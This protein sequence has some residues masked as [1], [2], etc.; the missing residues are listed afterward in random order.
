MAYS[1]AF[2]RRLWVAPQAAGAL[3]TIPNT[4]GTW[5][6]TGAQVIPFMG[7]PSFLPGNPV[8][9][10]PF[11]TGTASTIAGVRGRNSGSP[12]I[13]FP[14]IPSGTPATVPNSDLILKAA[15]GKAAVTG[16]GICTYS[17]ADAIL[18]F[19]A[20][21]YD[22]S[23]GSPTNMYAIGCLPKTLTFSLNGNFLTA[24]ADCG[25]IG[26]ADSNNFAAYAGTPDAAIAGGLTTFPAEPGSPTTAGHT[27][28]GFGGTVSVDGQSLGELRGSCA[29][30]VS[31]GYEYIE[32]A[33]TD[34]YA[35]T[36]INGP[37]RMRL[38]DFSFLNSDS[39]ALINAK[40]KAFNKTPMNVILSVTAGGTGSTVTFNLNNVQ[41]PQGAFVVNGSAVDVKFG[42]AT[43]HASTIGA[44]D[45]GSLV[46]S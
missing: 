31:C 13:D 20:L 17:F 15:F 12:K 8:N 2:R 36:A 35:L 18:P 10:Q 4:S 22:E 25:A 46:I 34:A 16:S 21:L 42:G 30:E 45:D 3:R 44:T 19:L 41:L 7:D 14:F 37:R 40:Q 27:V 26:V 38:S 9:D 5:T 28:T 23:G 6:N 24:T 29:V 39:A 32:D 33:F 1:S 43:A 11:I